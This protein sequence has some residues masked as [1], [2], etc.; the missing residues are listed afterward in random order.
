MNAGSIIASPF[1]VQVVSS[2][3]YKKVVAFEVIIKVVKKIVN[4][5]AEPAAHDCLVPWVRQSVDNINMFCVYRRWLPLPLR[6]TIRLIPIPIIQFKK[7]LTTLR[8]PDHLHAAT[9]ASL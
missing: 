2:S 9:M 7:I 3:F 6:R 4:K 8:I 1:D 5:K